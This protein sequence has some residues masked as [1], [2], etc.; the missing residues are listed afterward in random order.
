MFRRFILISAILVIIDQIT[1]FLFT[2]KT[3]MFTSF[4][5]LKYSENIGAAFSLFPGGR[6]V[7]IVTA[8]VVIYLVFKF[9]KTFK[10]KLG[11]IFLLAGAVGNLIDRVVL[12]YV[13][14][15]IS[16]WVWP[17][18][19]LADMLSVIGVGLLLIELIKEE[20]N[21]K[22]AYKHSSQ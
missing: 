4:F 9:Y 15:F 20:K 19:N 18:F 12:G 22:K 21:H 3:Y 13:R 1:K 14:D 17:V 16:V 7:F 6:L 2:G 11:L 5:G 8:L 10:N